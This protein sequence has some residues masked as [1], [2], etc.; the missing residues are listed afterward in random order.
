MDPHVP[1]SRPCLT[2]GRCGCPGSS[3]GRSPWRRQ[4]GMQRRPWPNLRT[5]SRRCF[6]SSGRSP[7]HL[8]LPVAAQWRPVPFSPPSGPAWPHL[9]SSFPVFGRP[10]RL[11]FLQLLPLDRLGGLLLLYLLL[12]N[13][14][15][16]LFRLLFFPLD[17]RHGL[18]QFLSSAGAGGAPSRGHARDHWSFLAGTNAA[19]HCIG[20]ALEGVVARSTATLA[21]TGKPRPCTGPAALK[22]PDRDPA[23]R[24]LRDRRAQRRW[25]RSLLRHR[26]PLVLTSF[27]FAVP[28]WCLVQ[29]C[30]RMALLP[31]ERV[32]ERLYARLLFVKPRVFT[33]GTDG[34]CLAVLA[35][36]G[37]L[38][39]P[40]PTAPLLSSTASRVACSAAFRICPPDSAHRDDASS[41]TSGSTAW[42]QADGAAR[43]GGV[44]RPGAGRSSR[45]RPCGAGTRVDV[46]AG[47][48]GHHRDAL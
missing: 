43:S 41:R 36:D 23:E 34:A 47:I 22:R 2:P 3:A 9:R 15:D 11:L 21:W 20:L 4:H 35:P 26:R 48:G 14:L 46:L 31:G 29:K 24:T 10:W 39:V 42:P 19:C 12:L 40:A 38:K 27:W 7:L 17:A 18:R 37:L 5:I 32:K 33:E 13:G 30:V 8:L 25:K 6:V 44:P 45:P 16:R 1:R 28:A